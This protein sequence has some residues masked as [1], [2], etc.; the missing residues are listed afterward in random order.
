M[1]TF[2]NV[3]CWVLH[4]A[5]KIHVLPMK[6][7]AQLLHLMAAQC[8][9]KYKV[10]G[11]VDMHSAI[12]SCPLYLPSN[13]QLP[14]LCPVGC[15][16]VVVCLHIE[17]YAP[18]FHATFFISVFLSKLLALVLVVIG[19]ANT[20]KSIGNTNIYLQTIL[21]Y[22]GNTEIGIGNTEYCNTILQY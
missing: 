13:C 2:Q 10:D 20:R 4:G 15:W 21:Q 5:E 1:L 17:L 14:S 22:F 16:Y 19:F 3:H 6:T 8:L 9:E 18:E 11:H 12:P 7:V